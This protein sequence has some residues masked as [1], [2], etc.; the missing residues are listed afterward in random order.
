MV[1]WDGLHWMSWIMPNLFDF[2]SKNS[3]PGQVIIGTDEAGR[4]PGAGPVFSAA[5]CFLKP[6]KDLKKILFKVN[7][8]KKLS[9]STREELFDLIKL[10]SIYHI[11]SSGVEEIEKINILQ[12]SLLSMKRAC[13][14]VIN[15]IQEQNIKILIDGNK[16]IPKFSV[17]QEYVIKGDSKSAS[18]AAASILAKVTRDHFMKDLAKEFPNYGWDSNK[19][20]LTPN[21][22]Q[23]IDRYGLTKWHRK[24]FLEK[25]FEKS[26]QIR[27]SLPI[28]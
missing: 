3:E 12:A 21:H 24:K 28:G 1:V 5:V 14:G 16:L 26:E 27:L 22:L 18:I 2:D 13:E 7:D 23:A 15:Q 10:N 9:E 17:T 19:G 8:S 11:A 20:Y 25:H 6:H 4:G